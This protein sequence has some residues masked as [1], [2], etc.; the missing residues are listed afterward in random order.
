MIFEETSFWETSFRESDCPGNVL[1]GKRLSGN[2]LS[3]K[4]TFR[5]MSVNLETEVSCLMTRLKISLC[6][7]MVS[8]TTLSLCKEV[9]SVGNEIVMENVVKLYFYH[10]QSGMVMSLVA[11]LS[12]FN[13]TFERLNVKSSVLF[14]GY[15]SR[16][17]GSSSYMKVIWSRSRSHEQKSEIPHSRNI[18][19]QLP[20]TPFYSRQ[21]HEVCMHHKVFRYVGSNGATDIYMHLWVV[22]RGW[23]GNLLTVITTQIHN[24]SVSPAHLCT[25]LRAPSQSSHG[26]H[27]PLPASVR[28]LQSSA[29][30]SRWLAKMIAVHQ[31]HSC[32]QQ[33]ADCALH[34]T[35]LRRVMSPVK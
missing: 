31:R 19:L 35:A 1:S 17:Y 34:S 27:E 14:C 8:G 10:P 30:C 15:I 3:G 12:V 16:A 22:C 5:E 23:E 21:S 33:R 6:S 29:Q 32:M 9:L 25:L 20:I 4:V 2:R 13:I 28:C 11:C 18:K 24:I 7:V 26:T